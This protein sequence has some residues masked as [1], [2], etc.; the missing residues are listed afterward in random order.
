MPRERTIE[1][2][3]SQRRR[4]AWTGRRA[5][6]FC[7]M[8]CAHSDGPLGPVLASYPY[9]DSTGNSSFSLMGEEG[10]KQDE[11]IRAVWC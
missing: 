6:H 3:E 8:V 4:Q 11:S 5:T 10:R 1:G 9:D 7:K 2:N